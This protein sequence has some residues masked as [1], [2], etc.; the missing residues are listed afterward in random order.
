MINTLRDILAVRC[1]L[2]AFFFLGRISASRAATADELPVKKGLELWFDCS[3]QNALRSGVL[4]LPPLAPGNVVDQLIDGSGYGRHLFQLQ[5]NARPKFRQEADRA[6]L[7]F[8]GVDDALTLSGLGAKFPAATIFIVASPHSNAGM[9]PG[10][11]SVNRAGQNDYTSG[12]NCDLGPAPSAQFSFLNIEGAGFG[13]ASQFLKSPPLPF[14]GWHV[15]SL[16]CEIGAAGV[17]LFL[18]GAAQGTR[19]RKNSEIGMDQFALGARIYSNTGEPPY[20]QGSFHGEIA[21]FL[22]YGRALDSSERTAVEQYLK[23]KYAPLLERAARLDSFSKPLVTVTNPPP[24]Q[25]F[26][27]GFTARELPVSLKNI[28]NVKYRGDGKLV[29][30]GYDGQIFLLSDA[31]G[32]GVE[33]QVRPFWTSNSLRAPIGMALTP[34]GY[35]KGQGVFV[36]AKGKL[37]LIVDTNADD[38]A[39]QEIIVAEGWK[40]LSHGVDALGVAVAHDGSIYF[41]I[42]SQDFTN[43]Y[44]IDKSSGTARYDLKSERGTILKVSSD[45]RRREIVCTGIRFSV[46]MAFN[47]AGDLFCTDQEGAT[48]LSNGNPFDE[49]LHIQE[50]RHYGFPPRHPKYLPNVIDEP[51][52]FDYAPQHESTCG[53]NF[54]EP[55]NGAPVFGPS[56]WAGDAL[57]CGYSRGKLWRTKLA[58]SETSYVA[59]SELIASLPTLPVDACVSPKGDLL[60][61][62][63][64]GEPD[65]GSGPNGSGHLYKVSYEQKELPQPVAVWASAPSELRIAFDRPLESVMLRDLKKRLEITQ[66]KYVTAGDRFETKRPGYAVVYSQLSQPRLDV[67]VQSVSF[68]PD[69]RNLVLHTKSLDAAEN[70]GITLRQFFSRRSSLSDALPQFN[71]VDLVADLQGLRVEWNPK[72]SGEKERRSWDGWLPHVD[73]AVAHEFL[74]GSAD[75]EDLWKDLSAPGKLILAGQLDL[76]QMLQPAVQP[77]SKLDYE[78]P[79]EQVTVVFNSSAPSTLRIAQSTLSSESLSAGRH[80]VFFKHKS[81]EAWLPFE[82]AL[83]TSVEPLQLTASWCTSEDPRPR[84]FP[85]RRFLLPWAKAKHDSAS[86]ETIEAAPELAGGN[87]LQG[88]RIFFGET[89]ACYKCH[90]VRGQ[91]NNVGPDLSN[92]IHRDYASVLKDIRYPNAALNPDHLSYSIQLNDGEEITAVLQK[93][94]REAITIA[95]ASGQ[96]TIPKGQIKSIKPTGLSLMPEGFDAALGPEQFKDLLTFLLTSPLDAASIEIPGLPPART[97]SEINTVLGGSS[98]L[99]GKSLLRILLCDGPKDHGLNEHDYPL[100]QTRWEKLLGLAQNVTVLKTHGF[101]SVELMSKAD[102]IV[103]Y[104]DNPGWSAEKVSDLRQFQKNGG[105]LVYLHFAVDGHDAADVLSRQIGLA[106]GR[107]AKFR[108]GPLDLDFNNASPLARG[109][110]RLRLEDESYWDLTGDEKSINVVASGIEDGRPRPLIWTRENGP[111]R[112]FVSI[113]GHYTWTFDDPLFRILILRGLCW[114]AHQPED[115][116]SELA[117]VGAR[118]SDSSEASGVVAQLQAR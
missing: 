75:H 37:A 87:W 39:D 95:D 98:S 97:P 51:S 106:W 14:S 117:V 44:L 56:W 71:D 108:H 94:N 81:Q 26:V 58:K 105:G 25:F 22:F 118:I 12:I 11:F 92:L 52:V 89:V 13:G 61:S 85:V 1:L 40:E 17:S 109:F 8:D 77:G 80:Q 29:A 57:V 91:G 96:K 54:N 66:G 28:N 31:D 110:S 47:R 5:K 60:I 16:K 30:L 99:P 20:V 82:L 67:P 102:V 18:D 19:D 112:V 43:P 115:R 79:V 90:S 84:A 111:G 2:I 63:H 72:S 55:V 70:Y 107:G 38:H 116:L 114:V 9:F 86:P 45:F 88:K 7:F 93:D 53:L 35:A 32:D 76:W 104:S 74:R 49:L 68:T 6:F 46:A 34:P 65:W 50:G 113:P 21:E 100:W 69:A 78:R 24:V 101:P 62:T 83:T 48:W 103:F 42:G 3:S 4:G 33:E 10:L 23:K 64:G 15:L 27:P 36:A 41:G 59:K 73:L